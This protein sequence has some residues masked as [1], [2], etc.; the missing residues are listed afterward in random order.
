M[1]SEIYKILGKVYG[2]KQPKKSSHSCYI[3]EILSLNCK[4][5]IGAHSI[6]RGNNLDSKTWYSW[7]HDERNIENKLLF[8]D[9]K[10]LK[11]ISDS[12]ASVTHTICWEHDSN[13]AKLFE[14]ERIVDKINTHHLTLLSLRTFINFHATANQ[15]NDKLKKKLNKLL[16]EKKNLTDEK[17]IEVISIISQKIQEKIS[18]N[19]II[20]NNKLVN[21]LDSYI[22][23]FWEKNYTSVYLSSSDLVDVFP[24]FKDLNFLI[25][26]LKK[27]PTIVLAVPLRGLSNHLTE[28]LE[29]IGAFFLINWSKKSSNFKK[30]FKKIKQGK[31]YNKHSTKKKLK[32]AVG[33]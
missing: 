16:E 8:N 1:N 29:R 31:K 13:F 14:K 24:L 26:P 23:N 17:D 3:G 28:R 21:L 6:S 30:N 32:L 2:L 22:K 7:E 4:K 5:S 18:E 12:K 19:E 20:L 25:I 27:Q 11:L 10:K 15:D 33:I 9:F